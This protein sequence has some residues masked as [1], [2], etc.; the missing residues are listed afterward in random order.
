MALLVFQR[1]GHEQGQNLVEQGARPKL[2]GLLR[3]LPKGLLAHGR[4][5]VLDL[6]Q[7]LHDGAL[8]LL[9]GRELVLVLLLEQRREELKV[10][11]LG[12]R[13]LVVNRLAHGAVGVLSL[14]GRDLIRRCAHRRRRR[15]EFARGGAQRLISARRLQNLIAGRGE[16]GIELLIGEGSVALVDLPLPTER[17]VHLGGHASRWCGHVHA[18]HHGLSGCH[19]VPSCLGSLIPSRSL[20]F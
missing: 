4:S 17:I 8:L 19:R 9:F 20:P 3:D 2:P 12:E 18:A 5:A 6:E 14:L 15:Q 11:G 13:E 7:E 10:L 1:R 16:H